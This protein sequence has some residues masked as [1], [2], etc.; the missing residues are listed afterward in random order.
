MISASVDPAGNITLGGSTEAKPDE[1]E[2]LC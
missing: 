2:P 1:T